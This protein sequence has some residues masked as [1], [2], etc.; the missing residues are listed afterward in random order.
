MCMCV[1]FVYV[2]FDCVCL[3]HLLYRYVCVCVYLL[4]LESLILGDN[5][6]YIACWWMGFLW[7]TGLHSQGLHHASLFVLRWPGRREAELHFCQSGINT[8]VGS[9]QW[10]ISDFKLSWN[11][12]WGKKDLKRTLLFS[13][14][15]NRL[16]NKNKLIT[17]F[18][19]H[20]S[21]S[22]V[23]NQCLMLMFN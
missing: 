8:V 14:T 18:E 1:S 9:V 11:G 17:H 22:M 6:L 19:I 20:Q 2:C 21:R 12:R 10:V 13:R 7:L 4:T 3:L 15:V 5:H 16:K 23:I